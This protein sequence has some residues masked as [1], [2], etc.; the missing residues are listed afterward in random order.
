MTSTRS[1]TRWCR[2]STDPE[3]PL[4]LG[5]NARRHVLEGFVGDEHLMHYGVLME[6]LKAR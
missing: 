1:A 4:R 2:C 5:E 6:R 3:K